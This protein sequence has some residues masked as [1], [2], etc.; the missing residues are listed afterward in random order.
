MED[1]DP[2][3]V[4]HWVDIT[5]DCLPLRTLSRFD[6]PLDAPEAMQAL[7]ARI[8]IAQEKHGA[9]NCYYLYNG[10][11]GFH[12]TND[13]AIGRIAFSFEG[14]ALTNEDDTLCQQC[15]LAVTL[16]EETCEWIHEPI[17][18]WFADSVPRAVGVEFNRFISAGDLDKAKARVAEI[19]QQSD[20]AGGFIGM[21]L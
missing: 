5:F 19:Q 10:R 20:E 16:A 2:A 3:P 11:C 17:V 7:L 1:A 21:Y 18:R 14:A 9:H 8:K 13:P 15:D 4:N 6:A 12:V